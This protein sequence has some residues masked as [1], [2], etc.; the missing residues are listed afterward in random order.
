MEPGGT[1]GAGERR[2]R[3][4]YMAPGA[5]RRHRAPSKA[6]AP[7]SLPFTGES[8]NPAPPTLPPSPTPASPIPIN[9]PIAIFVTRLDT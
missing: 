7:T 3:D 4:Q 6:N 2:L 5:P 1:V 8:T 9:F